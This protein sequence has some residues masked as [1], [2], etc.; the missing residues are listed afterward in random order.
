MFFC[1]SIYDSFNK[2]VL[3]QYVGKEM[4]IQANNNTEQ[5]EQS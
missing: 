3:N 1:S 4:L 2:S 5:C